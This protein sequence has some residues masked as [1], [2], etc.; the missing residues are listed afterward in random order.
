MP[1]LSS[2]LLLLMRHS[3]SHRRG[4]GV[5]AARI[6]V[7]RLLHVL[8]VR[9]LLLFCGRHAIVLLGHRI[10]TRHIRGLRR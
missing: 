8:S 6:R 7:L 3:L 1:M 10:P 5:L 9:D 2:R 4:H